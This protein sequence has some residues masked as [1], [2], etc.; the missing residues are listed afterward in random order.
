MIL[1]INISKSK[2]I[3]ELQILLSKKPK[4]NME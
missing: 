1:Y 3:K 4:I 2:K